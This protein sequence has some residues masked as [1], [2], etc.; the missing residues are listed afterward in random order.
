M[1]TEAIL[2]IVLGLT[3]AAGTILSAVL[4]T[5]N[6]KKHRQIKMQDE[7]MARERSMFE[8]QLKHHEEIQRKRES[9]VEH[10]R[11]PLLA[12]CV[13]LYNTLFRL[14]RGSETVV[15][16]PLELVYLF[17][18]Y[19]CWKEI[20]RTEIQE[21][22]LSDIKGNDELT[23]YISLM[24]T[25]FNTGSI[26]DPH[27]NFTQIEQR[28]IGESMMIEDSD[29]RGCIGFS[30]FEQKHQDDET[31]RNR[32]SCIDGFK[33]SDYKASIRLK[34]ILHILGNLIRII[35]PEGRRVH[36]YTVDIRFWRNI[37]KEISMLVDKQVQD[38]QIRVERDMERAVRRNHKI[39]R[40]IR[41][42][43]RRANRVSAREK[44]LEECQQNLKEQ[45]K[46]KKGEDHQLL[47]EQLKR[48][49]GDLACVIELRKTKTEKSDALNTKLN[50]MRENTEMRLQRLQSEANHLNE[51]IGGGDLPNMTDDGLT[52][53][54]S[55]MSRSSI[56][57]LIS[58]PSEE[59][60][61]ME[62]I[63]GQMDT[64]SGLPLEEN[65][66]T[67]TDTKKISEKKKNTDRKTDDISIRVE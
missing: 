3:T 43:Q 54:A 32:L 14:D 47:M 50:E 52:T 62:S 5:C 31:F 66:Q 12:S 57:T 35:D 30:E 25:A 4:G 61:P 42:N 48:C 33:L 34:Y 8:S 2:N 59:E 11:K 56:S 58:T 45:I 27:F 21:L 26:K 6:H 29:H 39:E 67:D 28:A 41:R 23:T 17:C 1:E 15:K 51:A 16:S 22:D 60:D 7:Q 13:D 53:D 18:Q 63:F 10:Y 65:F 9:R 46:M 44:E 49:D 38:Q 19:F 55:V 36:E 37:E 20:I 40:R 24:E 64:R